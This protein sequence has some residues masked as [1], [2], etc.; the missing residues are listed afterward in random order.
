MYHS[1][2]PASKPNRRIS[3]ID[4]IVEGHVAENR[5]QF[6]AP[7]APDLSEKLMQQFGR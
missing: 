4:A 5:I 2:P 1:S 3:C 7:M 6:Q